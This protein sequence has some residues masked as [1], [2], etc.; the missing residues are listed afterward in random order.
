[1]DDLRVNLWNLEVTDQCFN[2]IDMK[3]TNMD[4][5]T[6]NI[7]HHLLAITP[8]YPLHCLF[9][10]QTVVLISCPSVSFF[11]PACSC[12]RGN[13]FPYQYFYV[14]DLFNFYSEV[15]TSAEFHPL[16]CN[17]LAYSSS[18]GFIRLVDMRQSALCD[19]SA[20]M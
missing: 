16:H 13:S 20:R 14:M 5:L 9:I 1:M 15:I 4:D 10:F 17:L 3:P 18:R 6:G 8:L 19:H 2:I 7:G 12:L 11:F